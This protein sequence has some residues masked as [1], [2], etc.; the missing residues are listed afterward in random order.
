[1]DFITT[2]PRTQYGNTN[3]MVITCRLTKGEIYIPLPNIDVE[4]V[5]RAFI[6][7]FYAEHGLP[8]AITSDRGSQFIGLF[9]KRFCTIL[10]IEQR[11]STAYYPETDG[12][13]ERANQEVEN[14]LRHFCNADQTN[15]DDLLPVAQQHRLA[16]PSAAIG[17]ISPFFIAHGFHAR[18]TD[19]LNIDP[20]PATLTD[21]RS[22]AQLGEIFVSHL[23][24]ALQHARDAMSSAQARMEEAT[25]RHRDQSTA[26]KVGDKV[27][28]DTR[29]YAPSGPC[30]KLSTKHSLQTVTKVISSHAYEL[31]T[32][33]GAEKRFNVKYLRPAATDPL[34]SQIQD[35][36][37]PAPLIL[38]EDNEPEWEVES[39]LKHRWHASRGMRE[40]QQQFLVKWVGYSTSSWQWLAD[41]EDTAAL[42]QW[43]Q[44]HGGEDAWAASALIF[45]KEWVSLQKTR[46]SKRGTRSDVTG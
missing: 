42:E 5:A 20:V 8:T 16:Q 25:N 24:Q 38:N 11:L 17:G 37:Q 7:F 43:I 19:G 29:N 15:W 34:P 32:S 4:T 1:M 14:Y 40:P 12:A 9:W 36:Y 45:K 28:L 27:W 21:V 3:C 22:P 6:R 39:I 13:T 30:K 23:H 31:D 46:V 2:L 26:F 18:L 41:V 35:D 33:G 10:G 44:Q